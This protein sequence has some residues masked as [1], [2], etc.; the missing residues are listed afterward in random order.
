MNHN[1]KITFIARLLTALTLSAVLLTLAVPAPAAAPTD[2]Y[3]VTSTADSGPGTLRYAINQANSN[4]GADTI[5]FNLP[6]C[7][8]VCTISPLTAL[9]ALMD[10][11]TTINGYTQPGASPATDDDPA[12]ILVEVDGNLSPAIY[13]LGIISAGNTIQGLAI[14]RFK[15]NGI[16]MSGAAATGNVIA[17]NHIGVTASADLTMGNLWDGVY[18]GEGATDNLVGGDTRA[19]RNIIGGNVWDGVGIYGDGSDRN[20]VSGNYIG[21]NGADA[22]GNNFSGVHIYGGAKDNIVGG[23]VSLSAI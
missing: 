4:P 23:D 1:C 16:A 7:E 6:G 3:T 8:T 22:L 21:T 20:V 12:T 14:I 13:G 18:I 19:E 5:T 15:G 10:S 17:G 11:G 9:P 2:I